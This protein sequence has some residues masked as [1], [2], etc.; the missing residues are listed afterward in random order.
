MES[1]SKNCL[2]ELNEQLVVSGMS[3][4]PL[5]ITL[6]FVS[7]TGLLLRGPGILVTTGVVLADDDDD[8][9]G[10]GGRTGDSL[11]DK[12]LLSLSSL[13]PGFFLCAPFLSKM[14]NGHLFSSSL[15]RL[16]KCHKTS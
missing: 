3:S 16:V 8:D 13:V 7:G 10:G 6:G 5:G 12:T 15:P 1:D 9:P 2:E 14:E 4:G 11:L